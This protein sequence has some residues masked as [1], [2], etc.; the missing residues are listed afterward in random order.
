MKAL[1]I[2]A[3]DQ[4]NGSARAA[5]RL[6]QGLRLMGVDSQMLVNEKGTQDSHVLAPSSKLAQGIAKS[7]L[8]FDGLPLKLYRQREAALMSLQW[9]PSRS[10]STIRSLNP[11]IINL[12]WA[13]DAFVPIEALAKLNRPVAWSL[14]DMWAFTGGCH[15]TQTCDRYLQSCGACP[16]LGS[17]K[18]RDLSRWV[19]R[20]KR[21]AYQQT[22]LTIVALSHW[23]ADCARASTLLK[24]TR[25]EVIH[26]GIDTQCYRPIDKVIA[27]QL[28]CLPQDKQLVL[29]GA[30]QATSD[31]RKGLHLLQPA[32]NQLSQN[33]WHE[34]LELII[35]GATQPEQPLPFGFKTHYLGTFSD[36][37]SLA[38]A[39]SAAD[40]FVAP[41]IQENLANTIMESLACGTPCV[42][43]NIGG[44][45]DMI[46]HEKNGYL[47]TPFSTD[48]LASGIAWILEDRSRFLKLSENAREKVLSSFRLDIQAKRYRELFEELVKNAQ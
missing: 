14:H 17:Q 46:E 12:H 38:L 10:V 41:S 48:S 8:T 43:F 31:H 47:A 7:R 34:K 29:F 30:L 45:P 33:G 19:W 16:Q 35:L 6:Q 13:N 18:E 15:Y 23:L 3:Y 24:D 25:I 40:V 42:A 27:R 36:D 5:Y 11:D 39:Y 22:N 28:L 32:L 26:N 4:A 2:S 1:I 44:M 20:R 21:K 9:L 37:L